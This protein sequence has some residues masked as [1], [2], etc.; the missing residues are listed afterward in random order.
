MPVLI[1]IVVTG[2]GGLQGVAISLTADLLLTGNS[3]LVVLLVAQFAR[4]DKSKKLA[5]SVKQIVLTL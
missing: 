5:L 3:L 2:R 1:E 4:F